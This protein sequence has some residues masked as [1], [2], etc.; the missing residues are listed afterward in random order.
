MNYGALWKKTLDELAIELPPVSFN[1]FFKNTV[2]IT[3]SEEGLVISCP[4][5]GVCLLL[6]NKYRSLILEIVN[7]YSDIPLSTIAFVAEK[8]ERGKKEVLNSLFPDTT[9]T[10]DDKLKRALIFSDF[11]F[12]SFAVSTSN[13]MAHAACMAAA[14]SPGKTYN[15]L[16]LWGGV[17]VGKTHLLHAVGRKILESTHLSVHYCSTEDFTNALVDSIR[18]KTGGI[19]RKK[20]RGFDVLLLDDIQFIS[21]REFVQE[22]LFN[23]FNKLQSLGK[24][25][26]FTSD[27]PPR[28]IKVEKR[29]ISRFL[30]GLVIDIQ[31][32]DFELKAA[33]LMI[34]A[35]EKNL[36]LPIDCA[37]TI[38][39]H[40]E[41]LREL[42]GFILKLSALS[43]SGIEINKA[44]VERLLINSG[45]N[46]SQKNNPKEII[47][48][49]AAE[50]GVK[51]KE[52]KEDNR[53][54]NITLARHV[55]MY[56]L[57]T[58][59][60]LTYEDIA[61]LLEKK[62]HTTVMHAVGKIIK[63]IARNSDL[64]NQIEN[65]KLH[66]S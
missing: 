27:K 2:A 33:I 23:T 11:S 13:Q 12:D 14:Q 10:I 40:I 19:F 1:S 4:N 24:Q 61:H 42:E 53:K 46:Q 16:F 8:R 7:K 54:K 60:N 55:S 35:N 26:V 38:A 50:F 5:E 48:I 34:K 45:I 52:I 37:K 32:P 47:K 25:I 3:S 56:L 20:Y 62:D 59:T 28:A 15:P 43:K 6:K 30:S 49:T 41:E 44:T 31:Q 64:R 39:A 63:E 36:T 21:Q 22:E 65:I 57:K 29:L 18:N 51:L 58:L 9:N 17:G 66:F